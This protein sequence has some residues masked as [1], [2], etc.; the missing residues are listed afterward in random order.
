MLLDSRGLQLCIHESSLIVN[1]EGLEGF[2]GGPIVCRSS[3]T[4]S[5]EASA[6]GHDVVMESALGVGARTRGVCE[7]KFVTGRTERLRQI[8]MR[9]FMACHLASRSQKLGAV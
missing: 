6:A 5:A 7:P 3:G 2:D 8:N 4:P 9:C 1:T